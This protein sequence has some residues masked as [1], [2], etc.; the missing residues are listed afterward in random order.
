MEKRE[1]WAGKAEARADAKFE[2]VR[3]V[4]DNIPFGQPILVG[5]HSERRAR[6][7]AD[8]IHSGMDKAVE[9]SKLADHH[10]A[11]ARGISAQLERTVFTDDHNAAEA[12]EARIAEREAQLAHRKA[13]NAA[14]KKAP[15][16]NKPAKLAALVNDGTITRDEGMKLASFFGNCHWE[17]K[18]YPPYCLT[19]LGANIRRDRA[20]IDEVKQRAA[21]QAVLQKEASGVLITGEEW[22]RVTFAEKPEREVLDALRAAGFIWGGGSWNGERSKLPHDVAMMVAAL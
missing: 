8:R 7:D 4:A 5:H 2:S 11:K 21:V 15:G 6:R 10:E 13:V 20:R 16:D 17:E 1:E 12:L 9:L 22:V 19:N 14:F 3:K 18:P